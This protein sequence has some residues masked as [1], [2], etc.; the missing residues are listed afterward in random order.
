MNNKADSRCKRANG[1]FRSF[2]G[3]FKS[4]ITNKIESDRK[5]NDRVKRA[6]LFVLVLIL[7]WGGVKYGGLEKLRTLQVHLTT[8]TNDRSFALHQLKAEA[9]VLMDADTG[10]IIFYKNEHK[11]IFPASTTKILTALV[12]IEHG[13]L[14]EIVTVGYEIAEEDEQ[15]SK[16][17]LKKGD[18]L[19]LRELLI[20]LM[21]PSGNDATRTI[22]VHIAGK[23]TG[24]PQL[25]VQESFDYFVG[26]MN[27]RARQAGAT[28][29][30]FVNPHG[31]H[32]AN[33]Y[34]TAADIALIAREAMK[35]KSFRNIVEAKTSTVQSQGAAEHQVMTFTNRNQLLQE[36]SPYY[37]EGTTGIKTGFTDQAGYCLVSSAMRNNN[38][39]ISVVLHSTVN[40]V[41][42]DSRQM[43]SYGF[44]KLQGG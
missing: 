39:L 21:L 20:A 42:A 1:L 17:G 43:L 41:W 7:A 32:N 5:G 25:S 16:A 3:S 30:N 38:N 44:Q 9:A 31:L 27:D 6:V 33:H 36:K 13:D 22:A 14:D 12:T 35:Y 10:D 28:N 40:D 8:S 23:Q 37:F 2:I 19:S 15:E 4:K 11:K 26:M 34:S 29:S 18:R 24:N